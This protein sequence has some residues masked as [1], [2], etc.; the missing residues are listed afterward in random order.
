[1]FDI[2]TRQKYRFDTQRGQLSVEDLWDL[3]LTSQTKPNLDDIAK[4]LYREA[5]EN[6]ISFVSEVKKNDVAE[7]KLE[8]VKFIIAEKKKDAEMAK[9]RTENAA[10]RQT[11]AQLIAQKEQGQLQETP[12]EDLQKM[13]SEIKDY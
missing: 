12:I 9:R 11:I 2:A 10:R 13:L 1:M 8:I 6:E 5:Q 3:P 4:V 7:R